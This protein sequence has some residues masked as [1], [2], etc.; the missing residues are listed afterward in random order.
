MATR[1]TKP[2]ALIDFIN[3]NELLSVQEISNELTFRFRRKVLPT[4]LFELARNLD[5]ALQDD[6]AAQRRTGRTVSLINDRER[7]GKSWHRDPEH[8]L[9]S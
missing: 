7:H 9:N 6:D 2:I 5:F 3:V 4:W 1:F 8:I